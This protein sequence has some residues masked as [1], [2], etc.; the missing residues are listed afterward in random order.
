[1]NKISLLFFILFFLKISAQSPDTL[2]VKNND[3]KIKLPKAV[4]EHTTDTLV[5][6][7][8]DVI[9]GEI[10]IMNKGVLQIETDYSKDDFKLEWKELKYISSS[11][12]HIINLSSG[13]LLNGILSRGKTPNKCQITNVDTKAII[14]VKLNQIVYIKPVDDSFWDRLDASFDAGIKLTKAQK[15]AP[16]NSK[17]KFRLYCKKMVWNSNIQTNS[18]CA[19]RQRSNPQD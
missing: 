7:N 13:D 3:V 14:E 1:M 6:K 12:T 4:Y 16:I 15:P 9:I 8:N 18:V 17:C 19:G 2:A 11:K 5:L 10:K